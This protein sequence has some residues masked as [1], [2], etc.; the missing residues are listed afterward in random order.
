M[1]D[2]NL[3]ELN[4]FA[5]R[6]LARRT[7]V[8]SPT[9]K[10]KHELI[11]EIVEIVSGEK[12][13]EFSKSKQGRPPKVFGY[14]FENF[15]NF[16]LGNDVKSL[17]HQTFNQA[18]VQYQDADMITVAGWLELLNN[19]SAL[20][21]VE[22]DLKVESYFVPSE[23]FDGLNVRVADRVVAEVS[24][25]ENVKVVKRLFNING[26]PILQMPQTRENFDNV[27]HNL[28]CRNL[29]FD[30]SE[31]N[32]LNLKLGENA[33]FYGTNNNNNTTMIVDMLNSCSVQNKLYL[34]IS[35]AD[36]NKI[37]INKLN[38]NEKFVSKITDEVGVARRIV[39]LAIER[40]KRILEEGEDVVLVI[41]D[42]SSILGVDSDN[43]NLVKNLVAITKEGNSKGS[44]TIL[45][46]M[47]NENINQ[48]EKLADRRLKIINNSI[49]NIE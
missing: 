32:E 2:K 16:N 22:K 25:D 23:L 30:K 43:F 15:L 39:S 13:P 21:W 26:C 14:N 10:K 3:N 9:S 44:I 42:I 38:C 7:G 4:I 17:T 19:N 1:L 33:Y 34:N 12:K 20:L 18:K 45:A 24:L 31:F 37:F 5:L 49:V 46:I 28:P 47:P 8:S 35:V 41:D 36:K 40:A 6:D 11:S 29:E 27:I 48:I